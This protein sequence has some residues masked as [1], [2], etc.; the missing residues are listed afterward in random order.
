[1]IVIIPL[2]PAAPVVEITKFA[3]NVPVAAANQVAIAAQII[4]V[5]LTA[6]HVTA[7]AKVN[8]LLQKQNQL[9]Q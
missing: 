7:A 8:Q 2:A 5:A 6:P 9:L 3:T 4:K 1:M